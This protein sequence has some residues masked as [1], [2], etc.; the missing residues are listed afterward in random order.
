MRRLTDALVHHLAV[1]QA[2]DGRWSMNLPRPPIQ[3][4]DVSATALAI[5]AIG[6]YGWPGRKDEFA[7]CVDRGRQWLW[8][9]KAETNEEAIFQLLGLHW[10]GEPAERL[11]DLAKMLVDQQRPDGGWSQLPTLD[12]DAYATGQTLFALAQAAK[13]P[14]ADFGWQ[15]GLRFLLR[16]QGGDG[17][18]YVSRRAVPFQPTMPSGFAHGRDGWISASATSW[19]VMALTQALEPRT[20]AGARTKAQLVVPVA[21][22]PKEGSGL[23][24]QV[25]FVQHIKPVLE[26]SCLGCHGPERP[27]SNYR[28][29]S[30]TAFIQGGNSGEAAIVPGR[31]DQ[32]P[33]IEYV[34]GPA[35]I[36]E[37]PPP[38][39][40]NRF[41][42]LSQEELSRFRAWI[43]QGVA[44]PKDV[45]LGAS[46]TEHLGVP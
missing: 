40:R 25:D 45:I 12:S 9:I 24:P 38:A 5:L 43:D 17:S 13:R 28:V 20:V 2:A 41:P 42:G 3:S 46:P 19:A 29:D 34:S 44:W 30:R 31:S 11:A 27:R 14:V 37:M 33:F 16:T 1:I 4:S 39:Q 18:W 7:A 36:L 6:H 26:R 21:A 10:A 35:A 23:A 32:S 22:A 15:R 8:S